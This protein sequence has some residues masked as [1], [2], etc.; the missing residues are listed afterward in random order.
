MI[1]KLPEALL[2]QILYSLPTET[3]IA[4]SVLSKSWKSLWKL[5]PN[6]KFDSRYHHTFSENVCRSL[7]SHEAPF[8]ESLHL[9]IEDESDASDVGIWIGIAFAR[10]VRKLVLDF[11][12]QE[13]G[14]CSILLD[15]PSRVCF[16]SLRE[17]QLYFVEF[18]DEESVSNLLCGCPS[19]EDLVVQRKSNMDVETFTI[20]VPSLQRLSLEND[21]YGE[22]DGGYVINAPALKYLNIKGFHGLEFCLIEKAPELVEAKVSD[23][24]HIINENILESLTS[25]KRLSMG[26]PSQLQIKYPVGKIFYQL[27]SLEIHTDE[28]E[29]WNLLSLMLDS[30]PKL[31]ILKLIDVSIMM[32][33]NFTMRYMNKDLPVDRKWNQ[34]KCVHVCCSISRHLCG[35]ETN[36]NEKMRKK[37]P[38]T[39]LRTQ[40]A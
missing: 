21:F 26:L 15:L 31:Q 18:K 37:W 19:L 10:R 14:S 11:V 13:E 36:G 8:L 2:L 30:S 20:A 29:W 25:A 5:V 33:L 3:V 24:S 12:L 16:K 27:L 6:L 4:T 1:S 28:E 17:L 22:S 35:Q 39:S 7:I 34:P 9:R 32:I 23:V 38:N 40:D